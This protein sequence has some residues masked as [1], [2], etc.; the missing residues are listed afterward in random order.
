MIK[1]LNSKEESI[2]EAILAQYK[3]DFDFFYYGSRVKG[4]FEKASDLDIWIQGKS[5][6]PYDKLEIIKFLF[7]NS[8]LPFVVNFV[9]FHNIDDKFYN[10]IKKDLVKV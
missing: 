3:H 7:D 9:D 6:I 5:S 2:I 8:N 1:G 4:N 10:L